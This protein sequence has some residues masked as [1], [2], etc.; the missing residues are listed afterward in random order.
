MIFLVMI[1]WKEKKIRK[2]I[3][4]ISICLDWW[5]NNDYTE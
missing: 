1:D 3:F 5:K 2:F 4:E